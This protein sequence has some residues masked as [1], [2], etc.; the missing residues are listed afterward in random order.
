MV[1]YHD[2]YKRAEYGGYKFTRDDKTGYFLST[3][4]IG[5]RR[6][7][8]HVYV[9]EHERGRSVPAGY[10]IHHIDENKNNNEL[11]NLACIPEHGHLS[12]HSRKKAAEHPE[13]I[14]R[15]L[16]AAR[17]AAPAWHKSEPGREWHRQH[18]EKMK[19]ALHVKHEYAC[20]YCGK[21]FLS[22][23][24]GFCCNAHKTA[25]R[26]HLG[27]DNEPRQCAVCGKWFII[28]K[29]LKTKTCSRKCSTIKRIQTMKEATP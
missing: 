29:Y 26:Y 21:T 4:K 5:E 25:Y 6:K 3:V 18:Y 8:L 20:K 14:E 28:N 1:I 27:L 13:E 16:E 24:P 7:R 11:S 23:R 12:Y 10:Q 17:A 15:S 2:N 19:D 9:Y 22:N